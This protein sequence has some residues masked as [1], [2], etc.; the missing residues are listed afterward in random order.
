[1]KLHENNNNA[2]YWP[3]TILVKK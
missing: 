2:G 1:M 3:T